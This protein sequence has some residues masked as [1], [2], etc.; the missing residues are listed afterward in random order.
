MDK[1]KNKFKITE[2]QIREIVKEALAEFE[3]PENWR[4]TEFNGVYTDENGAIYMPDD[5]VPEYED[6]SD[7]DLLA[8]A[9]EVDGN[10]DL[11][12]GRLYRMN[13]S[14]LVG[15]IRES[16]RKCLLNEEYVVDPNTHDCDYLGDNKWRYKGKIY[17][18]FADYIKARGQDQYRDGYYW[19][20]NGKRSIDGTHF[21]ETVYND[22]MRKFKKEV[23]Y[24]NH[25]KTFNVKASEINANLIKELVG[26]FNKRYVGQFPEISEDGNFTLTVDHE[27]EPHTLISLEEL[28]NY[29]AKILNKYGDLNAHIVVWSESSYSKFDYTVDFDEEGIENVR[30][31]WDKHSEERWGDWVS[32][33]MASDAARG[34]SVD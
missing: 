17:D 31:E 7:E 19:W 34:W 32:R 22:E 11:M 4:D 12:L 6:V 25:G 5:D 3:K 20:P 33:Q 16:I 14:Q 21:A 23:M 13:E 24:K 26:P 2:S 18:S 10:P 1:S 28:N 8:Y 30:K 9:D 15:L 29:M 27:S